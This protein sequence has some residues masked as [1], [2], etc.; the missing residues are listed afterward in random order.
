MGIGIGMGIDHL[1]GLAFLPHCEDA[2]RHHKP[3]TMLRP[4]HLESTSHLYANLMQC[5]IFTAT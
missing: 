1:L 5:R 3:P 4:A 2:Y